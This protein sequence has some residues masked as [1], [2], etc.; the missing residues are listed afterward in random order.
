MRI[1]KLEAMFNH[2]SVCR[3]LNYTQHHY[4]RGSL[5]K[6]TQ[7]VILILEKIRELFES[8]LKEDFSSEIL[9][10]ASTCLYLRVYILDSE[11]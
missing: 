7:L 11:T 6:I 4:G 9:M 2:V 8:F 10:T 5:G 1:R 3:S